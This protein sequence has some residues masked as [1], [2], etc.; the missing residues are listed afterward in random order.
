M[1][2]DTLKYSSIYGNLLRTMPSG[3]TIKDYVAMTNKAWHAQVGPPFRFEA[4]WMALMDAPKWQTAIAGST[5]QTLSFPTLTPQTAASSS[6]EGVSAQ[7]SSLG[8]LSL[9]GLQ[10]SSPKSAPSS[11]HSQHLVRP[12]DQKAAKQRREEL[13]LADDLEKIKVEELKKASE[14]QARRVS[15]MEQG[16]II[17]QKA[18]D[19]D[20]AVKESQMQLTDIQVLNSSEDNCPDERSKMIL[21]QMKDRL[22]KKYELS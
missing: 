3:H 22:A 21:R 11:L 15:A 5:P 4:A 6:G 18:L 1:N 9:K 17:A 12:I 19:L 20:Q 10:P 7:G 8:E 13:S 2:T 16:N 14:V